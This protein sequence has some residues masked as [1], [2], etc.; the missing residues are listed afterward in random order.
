M[1]EFLI[2]LNL[3]EV[4]VWFYAQSIFSKSEFAALFLFIILSF[5]FV[6]IVYISSLTMSKLIIV[7]VRL[8]GVGTLLIRGPGEYLFRCDWRPEYVN[9]WLWIQNGILFSYFVAFGVLL[10]SMIGLL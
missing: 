10:G 2:F 7:I 8:I 1:R 4:L 6:F 5:F 9:W 3:V